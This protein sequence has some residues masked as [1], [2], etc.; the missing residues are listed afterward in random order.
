MPAIP[1]TKS[2]NADLE[3]L[4]IN[5]PLCAMCLRVTP[6][7]PGASSVTTVRIGNNSLLSFDH[8]VRRSYDDP[9]GAR[10]TITFYRIRHSHA[11]LD[12]RWLH[13]FNPA[14]PD[15][16]TVCEDQADPE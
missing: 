5:I 10:R 9:H 16:S 6:D 1:D 7:Y 2:T 11:E 14:Q 12:G 15:V 4:L 13:D 3:G 8:A